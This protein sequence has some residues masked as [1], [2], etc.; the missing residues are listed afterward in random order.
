M[1]KQKTDYQINPVEF[2]NY[3]TGQTKL[4]THE[5]ILNIGIGLHHNTNYFLH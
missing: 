5:T 3:S 2:E 1:T 4:Q